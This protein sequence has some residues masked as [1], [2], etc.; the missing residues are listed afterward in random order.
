MNNYHLFLIR[1]DQATQIV[2]HLLA[3]LV[4]LALVF[5]LAASTPVEVPDAPAPAPAAMPADTE[6]VAAHH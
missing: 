6:L 5:S 4:T 2:G 1:S 3:G